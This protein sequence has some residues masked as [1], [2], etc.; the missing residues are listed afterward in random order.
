MRGRAN[1][2]CSESELKYPEFDSTYRP[3]DYSE[4][5]PYKEEKVLYDLPLA[6]AKVLL[7]SEEGSEKVWLDSKALLID[8]FRNM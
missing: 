8:F 3:M 6:P 7:V 5:E 1:T 2:L 4:L